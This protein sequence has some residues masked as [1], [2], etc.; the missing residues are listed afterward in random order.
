MI[1]FKPLSDVQ[2]E[3]VEPLFDQ[4]RGK[5]KPHTPWRAV[6]NAVLYIHFTGSKWAALPNR[7]PEFASKSAAHRWMQRWKENALLDRI[8]SVLSRIS[9]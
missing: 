4:K 7:S 5:G 9:G 6:V 1:G 8:L 2:W 3:Q